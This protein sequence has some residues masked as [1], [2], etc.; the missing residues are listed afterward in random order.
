M[1]MN[2]CT[3]AKGRT[4]KTHIIKSYTASLDGVSYYRLCEIH[5][6]INIKWEKKVDQIY[7]RHIHKQLKVGNSTALELNLRNVSTDVHVKTNI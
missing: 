5:K 4:G 3:F 1:K 2:T 6:Y 7:H